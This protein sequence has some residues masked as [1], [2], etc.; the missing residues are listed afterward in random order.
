[1]IARISRDSIDLRVLVNFSFA[2]T[3]EAFLQDAVNCDCRRAHEKNPLIR[4]HRKIL[5]VSFEHLARELFK[6]LFHR[7][8]ARNFRPPLSPYWTAIQGQ[9]SHEQP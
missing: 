2:A 7:D 5:F 1:M 9:E 4:R 6:P 3:W 8:G